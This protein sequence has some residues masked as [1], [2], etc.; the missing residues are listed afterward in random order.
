MFSYNVWHGLGLRVL[1]SLLSLETSCPPGLLL[2]TCWC[3]ETCLCWGVEEGFTEPFYNWLHFL[4]CC[5]VIFLT[6]TATQPVDLLCQGTGS[7][8]VEL[9]TRVKVRYPCE[10]EECGRTT[11]LWDSIKAGE[12]RPWGLRQLIFAPW[13]MWWVVCPQV[14]IV[15]EVSLRPPAGEPWSCHALIISCGCSSCLSC[16]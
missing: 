9:V 15:V 3:P 5:E 2:V 4:L 7:H 8:R 13:W 12:S 6:P 16:Q 10:W 14:L 11:S 1:M